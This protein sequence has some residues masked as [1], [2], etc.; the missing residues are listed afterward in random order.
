MT[1]L[2]LSDFIM[3]ALLLGCGAFVGII[4]LCIVRINNGEAE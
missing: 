4:A 2:S 3:P 1:P